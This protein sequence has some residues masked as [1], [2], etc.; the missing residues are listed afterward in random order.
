MVSQNHKLKSLSPI[1]LAKSSSL[2]LHLSSVV[3][4]GPHMSRRTLYRR[5]LLPL[6]A[7]T[8]HFLASPS[9]L[10]SPPLVTEKQQL[11]VGKSRFLR[12]SVGSGRELVT[13]PHKN[14]KKEGSVIHREHLM[15]GEKDDVNVDL[16]EQM[17]ANDVE[18]PSES[19]TS[20]LSRRSLSL[21]FDLPL[22][23]VSRSTHVSPNFIPSNPPPPRRR[24]SSLPRLTVRSAV[25][26]VG[27]RE[28]AVPGAFRLHQFIL[29]GAIEF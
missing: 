14:K 1:S 7:V 20:K 19:I 25:T 15:F 4:A 9:D 24:H 5:I 22:L 11:G 10:P 29:S 27:Y 3:F 6:A 17:K 18:I 16:T 21:G 2:H 8:P 26:S 12:S 23:S 13:G 28:A